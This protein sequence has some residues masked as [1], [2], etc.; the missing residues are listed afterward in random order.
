MVTASQLLHAGLA[1][2]TRH[3]YGKTWRKF[4]EFSDICGLDTS[5][6]VIED[7]LCLFAAH[8]SRTNAYKSVKGALAAIRSFH[9]DNGFLLQTSSMM[10]L[11]RICDGI[12]RSKGEVSERP[13]LPITVDILNRMAAVLDW[14]IAEDVLLYAISSVA[15]H[16]LFRLGE[17]VGVTEGEDIGVC[18][19]HVSKEG[20][21]A[22]SFKLEQSKTDPFRHG[23]IIKVFKNQS[24]SCPFQAF[25]R[26]VDRARSMRSEDPVFSIHGERVGRTWVTKQLR[27][28]LAKIGL[29]PSHYSGHSFR[30]GGASSL[31]ER[32]VPDSIIKVMGRW[33]SVAYQRYI[34][35]PDNT[36]SAAFREGFVPSGLEGG[37]PFQGFG[38][39]VPLSHPPKSL[40]PYSTRAAAIIDRSFKSKAMPTLQS[41]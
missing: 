5:L 36:I 23:V 24:I 6:P 8:L 25:Q 9:T 10:R 2:S 30:K 34:T 1:P 11:M 31:A 39:N 12:R 7:N 40:A 20:D 15:T 26:F 37:N 13:R 4:V 16:G 17:L 33:K 3:T 35:V 14:S 18:W 41:K 22:W 28:C 21:G 32:G 27:K 29:E 19:K 38:G